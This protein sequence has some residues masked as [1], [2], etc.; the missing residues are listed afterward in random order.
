[1]LK[2]GCGICLYH[3]C[4]A[5]TKDAPCDECFSHGF[6]EDNHLPYFE[7][8]GEIP[9]RKCFSCILLDKNVGVCANCLL[10]YFNGLGL[11]SFSLMIEGDTD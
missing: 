11:T 4:K 7:L 6:K 1:M 5:M 3:T 8:R 10:D 9:W 2:P